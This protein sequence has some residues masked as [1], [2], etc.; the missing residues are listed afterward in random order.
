MWKRAILHSD[1]NHCYAQIEEMKFPE[2]IDVPMVVGGHE[3]TRH[4]IVLAK[5]DKA[6]EFG[7][8]T[9]ETLKDAYKK[10]P[11]LLVIHPH[12][13]DYLYYTHKVNEIYAEYSDCVS[14]MGIDEAWIDVT[15][16]QTLYGNPEQIA[17]TIQSRIKDE[18]GLNVS[19]GVSYNK[20]FAKLGSD[21]DK[22]SGLTVISEE[23]FKEKVWPRDVGDLLYVG[24]ATKA[25]L[26]AMG[27]ETIGDLANFSRPL[28]EK[29]LGKMGLV[30]HM[31]A[32][33]EDC[34]EVDHVDYEHDPKSVGNGVTTKHDMS[35]F[36][37][38]K[39]VYTVLCES[40]ATR[41]RRLDKRGRV[42]KVGLRSV[43][44]SWISHQVKLSD[45]TNISL[46]ILD[47]VMC[48]VKE[49]WDFKTSLRSIN[50]TVSCLEKDSGAFQLNLFSDEKSRIEERKLDEAMEKIRERYGHEKV[51]R[52]NTLL[53]TELSDFNPITDHTIHP[54][55]YF[56]S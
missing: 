52:C 16:S 54:V 48:L 1:L 40:V 21:M 30:I 29:K 56:K 43:D 49:C 38:V 45:A 9:A 13:D 2:L 19:I 28:I 23:N 50:V 37:D 25:K 34:G 41:L 47:V 26:L 22:K 55:G 17:K 33:G 15:H 32:N 18:L 31:F 5:N 44:L 51:C 35:N 39:I 12:Y 46:E 53:D 20:I 7:I 42:I 6:K 3:E 14:G 10:C 11:D 27:I 8:K 24:R 4:G 36:E